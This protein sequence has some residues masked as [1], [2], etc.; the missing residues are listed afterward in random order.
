MGQSKRKG[1]LAADETAN[2]TMV[3][4]VTGYRNQKRARLLTQ[5]F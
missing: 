5:R 1:K 3:P 4:I 2:K